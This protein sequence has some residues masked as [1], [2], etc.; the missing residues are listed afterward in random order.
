MM[1]RTLDWHDEL[2]AWLEPFLD[3]LGHEIRRRMSPLQI[4]R[5][6]G[7]GERKSVQPPTDRLAV[8]GHDQLH[9]FMAAGVWDAASRPVVQADRLIGDRH[10]VLAIVSGRPS[11]WLAT[12]ARTNDTTQTSHRQRPK[13]CLRTCRGARSH[14]VAIQKDTCRRVSPRYVCVSPTGRGNAVATWDVSTCAARRPG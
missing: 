2:E 8:V 4:V 14:G 7:P 13:L 6:I 1:Q 9:H 3:H 12:V 5:L 11:P 10:A